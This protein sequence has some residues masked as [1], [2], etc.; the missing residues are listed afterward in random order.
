MSLEK[1]QRAGGELSDAAEGGGPSGSL[2]GKLACCGRSWAS[3]DQWDGV[4]VERALEAV[5]TFTYKEKI[6]NL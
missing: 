5:G 3:S 6:Y 1:R 4:D 2:C